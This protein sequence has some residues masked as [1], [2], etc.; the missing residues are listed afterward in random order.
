[1]SAI[2][3]SIRWYATLLLMTWAFA[4]VARLVAGRLPG[5]GA[6]LAKPLGLLAT[7]WPIWFLASASPLPYTTTLLWVSVFVGGAASWTLAWRAGW[8]DRAWLQHLLVAEV[9]SAIA[10]VAYVGFRGYV[11]MIT[12]TEKPM[13]IALL[14]S[15]AR[16]TDM[17][18][19]DPWM[20]GE[21]LNYYYLGYA[22]YGSL[23]RMAGVPT[24]VGFNLALASTFAMTLV[25]A[26]GL[27]WA[28]VRNR[29]GARIGV[30][31]AVVAAFGIVLAGNLWSAAE[32][33][34]DPSGVW[35]NGWWQGIGWN[36]SRVVVDGDE[37]T[38]NEFP[39]FSFVLGDLHPHVMALPFTVVA[40]WIAVALFERR[41]SD[42]ARRSIAEWGAL[43]IGGAVVGSLYPMNSWDYPTFL[44][45]AVVALAFAHGWS[46]D[47][48]VR[49]G[50]IGLASILAWVPFWVTFVPFA[51]GNE[52]ELP[53]W[54]QSLPI[55]PRVLSTVAGYVG[56][57]TTAGEFLGVFGLPW[58]IAVAALLFEVSRF[59]GD[60]LRQ[61]PRWVVGGFALL[62]LIALLAPFPV[63]LLAGAPFALA[64]GL[65]MGR[66]EE[67]EVE[68]TIMLALLA[69][70]FGLI[71]ITELFYVQDVFA[72]RLNTLFKVYFQVWTLLGIAGAIGVARLWK[73][74][75]RP[76]AGRWIIGSAVAV[77]LLLG[78]IYPVVSARGWTEA[79]GPGD[80][81]G[82]DGTAFV[83]DIS[84]D[85]LAAVKW[86][87]DNAHEGDVLVEVPGC[88]YTVNFGLVTNRFSAFTGIP[89]V[90]GWGGHEGQWRKGQPDLMAGIATRQKDVAAIFEA[91]TD[92]SLLDEY[93]VTLLV[94]GSFEREGASGC[95]I[96]GPF[97]NVLR[98][99]FPGAGWTEV[100]ASGETRIFRRDG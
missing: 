28:L 85:D 9:V 70:A 19:A 87:N 40:L 18:P 61:V 3:D 54:I 78:S 65:L 96:A 57:R 60:R 24:W 91:P 35:N 47:A 100:F 93:G 77:I 66:S 74:S 49:V 37:M 10:F 79:Q 5:A 64:L 44:G 8:F 1:M 83:E 23:L 30:L 69:A 63:L 4:P 73:A 67:R 6:Y 89:T 56:E 22:L 32:W 14:S 82:L 88:S 13:D 53:G 59:G 97:P 46:K 34:R 11:P 99:G 16:A 38:I 33:I 25:A 90:I 55:L 98:P 26:G 58:A 20:A 41:E 80:W 48:L 72:G 27:G 31:A 51:G 50:V 15:S 95:E 68:R 29:L 39:S 52:E 92:D 42:A 75:A 71:L 12:G 86:L 84:A 45:A 7:V 17:P 36:A 94:A 2:P 81:T 43:S 76:G 62:V 21:S